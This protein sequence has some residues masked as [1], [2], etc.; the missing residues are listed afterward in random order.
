MKFKNFTLHA[1]VLTV[2]LVQTA[3]SPT[4]LSKENMIPM[5]VS[6]VSSGSSFDLTDQTSIYVQG[7][8]PELK[9]IGQYLA[10]KLNPSTGLGVKAQ[11][12]GLGIGRAEAFA[13]D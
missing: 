10:D 7:E 9:Q 5:P 3:C 1:A 2:I 4:S 8:S 6:V 13:H 11:H 12:R